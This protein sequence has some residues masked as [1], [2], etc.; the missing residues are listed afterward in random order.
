MGGILPDYI[1]QAG[2][3]FF[4][5]GRDDELKS[6]SEWDLGSPGCWV[7]IGESSL[8]ATLF[9]IAAMFKTYS[10]DEHILNRVLI[11]ESSDAWVALNKQFDKSTV[12]IP[13]FHFMGDIC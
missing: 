9:I 10:N 4:L 5:I 7:V 1:S 6:L 8:E 11:V 3:D 13:V 2:E 12:L